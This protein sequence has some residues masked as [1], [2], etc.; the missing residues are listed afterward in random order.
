MPK[1]IPISSKQMKAMGIVKSKNGFL[2][3][4][5]KIKA[6]VDAKKT[7]SPTEEKKDKLVKAPVVQQV[8]IVSK[9]S[10]KEVKERD[11]ARGIY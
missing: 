4:E 2:M 6:L 5:Q 10:K 11:A 1:L 7:K 9:P 8:Q 3:R